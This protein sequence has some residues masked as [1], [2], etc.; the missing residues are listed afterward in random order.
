M[1]TIP[2]KNLFRIKKSE[3]LKEFIEQNITE[4]NIFFNFIVKKKSTVNKQSVTINRNKSKSA[5]S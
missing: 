2:K 5:E 1:S 4:Q 3:L